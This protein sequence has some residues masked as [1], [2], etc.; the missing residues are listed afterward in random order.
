M[1]TLVCKKFCSFYKPGRKTMKCGSYDFLKRNLSYGELSW[2]SQRAPRKHDLSADGQIKAL[3]CE[4]G[5]SFYS[6]DDC[7][8]RL[9]R[10]SQP[11]G[12]YAI[13]ESLLR[14]GHPSF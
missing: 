14:D 5:C 10:D 13:I 6:T 8:F 7:D 2:A 3:I 11:C 1:D 9:G 4:K 12:G